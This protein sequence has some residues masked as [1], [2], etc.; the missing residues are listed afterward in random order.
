V[1]K[2]IDNEIKIILD[3][4]SVPKL[5]SFIFQ[6]RDDF[7]TESEIKQGEIQ[8]I[9]SSFAALKM[10]K[11]GHKLRDFQAGHGCQLKPAE[12]QRFQL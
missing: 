1:I 3:Y 11:G 4:T 12:T 9:Q 5:V 10:G 7:P 8:T 6:K 2:G